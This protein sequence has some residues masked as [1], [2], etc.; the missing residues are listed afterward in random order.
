MRSS[1]VKCET[2]MPQA[3][4]TLNPLTHYHTMHH[5][6]ALKIF[7]CGKHC[8]KRR[9]CLE[10]AISLFLTM[11]SI[12][13]GAH[14]SFEIYFEMSSAICFNLDQSEILSSGNG[15]NLFL[16][17][18]TEQQTSQPKPSTDKNQGNKRMLTC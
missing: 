12:L 11:F 17:C 3:R 7:S 18:V 9:N 13:Y 2:W 4:D 10:Q 14:F 16:G 6:D 15:L 5:F 1:V 8:E